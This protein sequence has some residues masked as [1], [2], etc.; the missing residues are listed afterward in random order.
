MTTGAS[1]VLN[2]VQ[3]TFPSLPENVGFARA[4]VAFF[5]SRL[6]FTLDELDEIKVAVSEAVSNAV[7]HAYP[8]EPGPILLEICVTPDNELSVKVTDHGRG[9]DDV[10]RA[11]EPSFTTRP[12]ERLG[13]GLTF[14]KEYAD[15]LEVTSRPGEGTVVL[16]TKRPHPAAVSQG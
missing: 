9:I 7:I 8:D 4:A 10:E 1:G 5:A 2:C 12:G 6:D 3:M 13:L 16:F 11:C 14:I 15:R